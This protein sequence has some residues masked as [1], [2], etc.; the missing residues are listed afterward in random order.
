[1]AG[2]PVQSQSLTADDI[3]RAVHRLR[4]GR[5]RAGGIGTVG[6]AMN[7]AEVLS[8]RDDDDVVTID[9]AAT[10]EKASVLLAEHR[11]G[12]VVVCDRWG[13]VVGILS[14]RDIICALGERGVEVLQ[15][16]VSALMSRDVVSCGPLDNAEDVLK[17]MNRHRFRHMPVVDRRELIGMVSV[18]DLLKSFLDTKAQM[19]AWPRYL[20]R[21]QGCPAPV[22]ISR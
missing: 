3:G 2:V 17:R 16:P 12:A 5:G 22:M 7:I 6:A 1:M 8:H 20:S 14:E 15:E 18:R 11:I 10:L 9:P 21:L 4:C 19:G 13:E